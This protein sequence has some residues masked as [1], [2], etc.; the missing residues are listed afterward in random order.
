M[1]EARDKEVGRL[2]QVGRC[3]PGALA[4]GL[5]GMA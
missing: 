3:A 4:T 1:V 2:K 5:Q